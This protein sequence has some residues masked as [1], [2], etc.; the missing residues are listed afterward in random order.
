MGISKA[1]V[2]DGELAPRATFSSS[3]F[4]VL[5]HEF[6]LEL[7]TPKWCNRKGE[8]AYVM[9][10]ENKWHIPITMQI[11]FMFLYVHQARGGQEPGE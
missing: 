5:F 6:S 1:T 11:C 3:D 2:R 10:I 7:E 4:M 8:W 9:H